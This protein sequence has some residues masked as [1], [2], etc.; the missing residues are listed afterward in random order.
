M[1]LVCHRPTL[2]SPDERQH[3]YAAAVRVVRRVPLRCQAT[4][5]FLA[6]LADY[7]CRI[8][9][10]RVWF[11]DDVVD[12]V[13][14]LIAEHKAANP[15][16]PAESIP[17]QL[18]Y[19]ASGQGLYCC[20]LETDLLRPATVRDLA[21]LSRVVDAIPG[22]GR[23]H[24]TFIPTDVPRGTAE[25]H[26]FA[27]I[28][29]HSSRPY[30]V[31]VYSARHLERFYELDV[32]ARGGDEAAV[33][34]SPTFACKL[35]FNS[36]FM[37]TRENIEVA[38]QG[39]A[40]Y[41]WPLEISI[42]PVAGASTP[43]T[44]AGCLVHQTAESIVCNLLTLAIDGR[45]TGY[46]AGALT[47]DMRDG[48]FTQSGPDVDL[49]QLGSTEM[50]DFCFGGSHSVSRGPTTTAKVPGAQS[51]MEKSIATLFA[52]LG[53]TR[54]FGSLAVLAT[55]D[56]GSLTQLMLDVEMMEYFQRLLDGV[57]VDEDR[58]AE[59]VIAE[60]SPTGARFM[61]HEHT[62]RYH[63]E[64]LYSPAL[65]DRRVAGAWIGDPVEMV[66]RARAMARRLVDTAENRC[67]LSDTDRAQV[68]RIVAEADARAD[69]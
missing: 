47:T 46:R 37:I 44:L 29:L 19:S 20:D 21:G 54:S 1:K 50:A 56:V 31:S 67:R 38:M 60:V 63:R 6:P 15:P 9:G 57:A 40:L 2:L 25:L 22:L 14:A 59:E 28:I 11:P 39:R 16:Q 30:R 32:I 61:E 68:R 33:L 52:I 17:A 13:V 65:A 51:M 23:A 18:D 10:E 43:V 26:A 41:G 58:L 4:D 7:G 8:D 64:E 55:A 45:L 35:W 48:G 42:M 12:R 36:P 49:V 24:P 62:A 69:R 34:R 66:E 3:I 53:G 5:E 27:T